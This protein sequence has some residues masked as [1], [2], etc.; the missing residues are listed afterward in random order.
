[1][2]GARACERKRAPLPQF[3]GGDRGWG[4]RHYRQA[5]VTKVAQDRVAI[6]CRRR[7]SCQ[8]CIGGRGRK[9]D[10]LWRALVPG[11]VLCC[12]Q[13]RLTPSAHPNIEVGSLH[14]RCLGRILRYGA[15]CG[16]RRLLATDP[17]QLSSPADHRLVA[18]SHMRSACL[19]TVA[20]SPQGF[21][22][23][24]NDRVRFDR[25]RAR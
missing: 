9:G 18:M 3:P 25:G 19:A 23:R 7:R 20:I 13:H 8:G 2:R 10:R 17:Q 16:Q 12:R 21:G 22:A 6:R 1:M 14:W 15:A 4:G 24:A 11:P 5:F